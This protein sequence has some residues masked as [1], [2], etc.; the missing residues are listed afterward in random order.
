MF[1]ALRRKIF[2]KL[3]VDNSAYACPK[4]GQSIELH[5]EKNITLKGPTVRPRCEISIPAG[6]LLQLK[7]DPSVIPSHSFP[8]PAVTRIEKLAVSQNEFVYSI[9]ASG[10]SGWALIPGGILTAINVLSTLHLLF[11]G[12]FKNFFSEGGM[13][14]L[15]LFAVSWIVGLHILYA[16]LRSKFARHLLYLGTDQIRLNRELYGRT[17]KYSLSITDDTKVSKEVFYTQNYQPVYGIE[18]SSGKKQKIRFG[19]TLNDIE[20]TWLCA[21]IQE[22]L[23]RRV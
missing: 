23:R 8:L 17:K 19:S 1:R 15:F 6:E 16:G 20:K 14:R 18:I 2:E 12:T 21:E 11:T 4:C 22:H 7:P 5:F 3:W 13:D 10:N 9:P